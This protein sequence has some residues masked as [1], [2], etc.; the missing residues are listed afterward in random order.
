MSR[1]FLVDLF[2]LAALPVAT[3]PVTTLAVP[4]GTQTLVVLNALA[5]PIFVLFGGGTPGP[6]QFD[7]AI[8]GESLFVH[9]IGAASKISAVVV[10]AGAVPAGDTGEVAILRATDALWAPF[11]GP[12]NS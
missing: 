1:C 11:V 2:R 6:G 9:P 12:L 8:P 3:A 10:Y 5:A 4:G 7:L